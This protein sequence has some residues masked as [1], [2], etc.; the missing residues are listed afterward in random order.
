ML[1]DGKVYSLWKSL[2]DAL[3]REAPLLTLT[4]GEAAKELPVLRRL[5]KK[6]WQYRVDRGQT[7]LI[8]GG[9]SIMD[10]AGFAAATWKR[11]I[12]FVSLPTTF[13]AQIDAAIGGKVGINFR[14]GK[15]LIGTYAEPQAIWLLP[16]FLRS[17]P[18]RE[19]RAGWVE[20]YKHALLD[21]ESLW[22]QLQDTTFTTIPSS[23]MLRSLAAVKLRFVIQDPHET[24]GIRQAL[25]LGHTLGHVWEALAARTKSPLLHGEAVAIGM[26]QEL[27]LSVRRGLLSE[28]LWQAVVKK[29]HREG[30]LLPLP[31]FTWRQWEKYLLQDKK[32]R[33][34]QL[35]LP[36][37]THPGAFQ[38][39]P[40]TIEELKASI[41]IYRGYLQQL[42]SS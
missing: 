1:C 17:L 26:L 4:G 20:G 30:L 2:I 15:N 42:S 10:A 31:P 36:L 18:S 23:D 24:K 33:D 22:I 6:L 25:N 8:V 13:V 35:L 14:K 21:G 7:L 40:I 37:L 3:R 27:W 28:S 34:G 5:W 41:R 19:L 39:S 12:P 9:G 11:G 32:L 29:F 38:L 16:D